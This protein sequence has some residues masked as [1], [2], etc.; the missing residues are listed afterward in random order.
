MPAL[1]STTPAVCSVTG[2]AAFVVAAGTCSITATQAGNSAYAAAAPVTRS[3]TVMPVVAGPAITPGG[4]APIS[5]SANTI[6]PG[7][8]VSI[9]GTS[10]APAT[11]VWNGNF[12]ASLAGVSVTINGKS[13]YLSYV[14]P[15]QINLQAPDDTARGTV[16]V[17]VTNTNGSATATVALA[18]P[19]PAYLLLDSNKHVAGIILRP[20]GSGAFGGGTYDILGPTGASLGY[21]TVA[22]K[23][24]DLVEL[25]GTGF[26]AD[27]FSGTRGTAIFRRH[28]DY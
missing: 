25:F 15:T 26:R 1:A 19:A 13:A 4:I 22:A 5:G 28:C 21:P 12:P 3:F 16:D 18:D 17:T 6:Q 8:W 2:L 27:E 11:A 20:D 23:P 10:L 7:S 14:S 24:G 9:Y